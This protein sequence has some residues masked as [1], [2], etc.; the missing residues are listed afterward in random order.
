MLR[1]L[2]VFQFVSAASCLYVHTGPLGIRNK[3]WERIWENPI[4]GMEGFKGP[5]LPT[6]K[7]WERPK[8]P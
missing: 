8:A 7:T 6:I 5:R 1:C 3:I 4:R 2:A